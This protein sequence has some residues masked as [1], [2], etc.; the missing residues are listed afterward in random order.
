MRLG[1]LTAH[2]L[3]GGLAMDNHDM[4]VKVSPNPAA[5]LIRQVNCRPGEVACSSGCMPIGSVCCAP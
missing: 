2:A 1:E 5:L 3:L 4:I